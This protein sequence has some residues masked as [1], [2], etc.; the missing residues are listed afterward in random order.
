MDLLTYLMKAENLPKR[1]S[2]SLT[3]ELSQPMER[4]TEGTSEPVA[5]LFHVSVHQ[6]M[7]VPG[8]THFVI[9]LGTGMER[10]IVGSLL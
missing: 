10:H 1:K 3:T 8:V 5:L 6:Q 2:Q 7:C 9:T 4:E